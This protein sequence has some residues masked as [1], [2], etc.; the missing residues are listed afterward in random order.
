MKPEWKVYGGTDYAMGVSFK[1]GKLGIDA[2]KLSE[3]GLYRGNVPAILDGRLKV[4]ISNHV[5]FENFSDILTSESWAPVPILE[6]EPLGD[7]NLYPGLKVK[8]IG[9]V[10]FKAAPGARTN[11]LTGETRASLNI[12]ASTPKWVF[13][14]WQLTLGI[15]I[16]K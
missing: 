3:Y 12:K 10:D 14:E 2:N 7:I 6:N 13:G 4:N 9:V 11:L 16:R 1:S 8:N 5:R 15:D